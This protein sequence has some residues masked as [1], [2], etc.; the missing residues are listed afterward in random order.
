MTEQLLNYFKGD[1]LA[2]SVWQGKYALKDSFDNPLEETPDDMHRRLAKEFYRVDRKYQKKEKFNFLSKKYLSLYGKKRKQLK[3]DD[4]YNLF[5]DFKYIVPQG[6]IMSQLGGNSIGSLS[7]CFVV[8]QPDDSY[9]GIFKKDE[10]MAQLMK[11]RGGVG[12][13]I[14]TLRPQGTPTSNA[15][16][17]STGA[18]SFMH[19]FSNTTREVAQSGRRGK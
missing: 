19:R 6:S 17:S 9:G 10:E 12:I 5:K 16:K 13:D 4:V 8:G 3:E 11:R 1:E 18:V 2:S 14:S 7:N 15:A